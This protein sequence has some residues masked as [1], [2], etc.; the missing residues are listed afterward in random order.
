MNITIRD[1]DEVVFRNFKAEA[2]R[3]GTT[4]GS[5]M[6]MAMKLWLKHYKRNKKTKRNLLD[7]EPF[8]W[9]EGTD[10]SSLEVDEIVYGG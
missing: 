3:D 5:A 4:L 6:T 1:V 7:L 2:V 8:D 10:R 9:G